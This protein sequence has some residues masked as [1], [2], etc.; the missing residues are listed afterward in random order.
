M[1]VLHSRLEAVRWQLAVEKYL[2]KHPQYGFGTLVAFSG[3][4]AAVATDWT[5]SIPA[6]SGEW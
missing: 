2:S 6:R 4:D 3:D 5:S 1:V